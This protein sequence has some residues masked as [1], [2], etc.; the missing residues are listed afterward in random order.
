[1]RR[2]I[3]IAF[4]GIFLAKDV[5][6]LKVHK[7]PSNLE[8]LFGSR[9]LSD[10]EEE[11][12]TVCESEECRKMAN[13]LLRNMNKSVSPCDDFYEYACGR[14]SEQNPIPEGYN[15]W[16]VFHILQINK[17]DQ[18]VQE[19]VEEEPKEDDLRA[20]KIAKKWYKACM[21]TD[22][23]E[24]QGIDPL[25]STLTCL[26]GWPMI[27]DQWDEQEYN[28]QKVDDQ[29]MR[30]TGR[31]AFYDVRV[32]RDS[33]VVQIDSPHLPVG[34]HMLQRVMKFGSEE[35]EDDEEGDEELSKSDEDPSNEDEQS[36]EE[37]EP[38]S[39]GENNSK[40]IKNDDDDDSD[41]DDYKII[42]VD[43]GN[44]SGDRPDD[45]DDDDD[46]DDEDGNSVSGDS[47]DDDDD[48]NEIHKDVKKK[49]DQKKVN[50]GHRRNKK[51]RHVG[52]RKSGTRIIKKHNS[53]KTR[54]QKIKRQAEVG[55]KRQHRFIR[56]EKSH[57]WKGD[58]RRGHVRKVHTK[59]TNKILDNEETTQVNN[60]QK[61]KMTL[62]R[63]MLKKYT[64]YVSKV[65][66]IIA[67]ER[68]TEI[69]QDRLKKDIEDMF[70]FHLR[71]ANIASTE[72][73]FNSL[74]NLE[75]TLRDFQE[76]YDEKESET[77]KSKINWVNKIKALF[78][79][80]YESVNDDLDL[81]IISPSYI[82][83]LISLLDETSNR[84][85]VNYIH[86]NFISRIIKT[87]T[88][89]M[90]NLYDEWKELVTD[91]ST[92]ERSNICKSSKEIQNILAYEF[93]RRYFSD[94]KMRTASNMIKDIKDAVED[95]IKKSD[96]MDENA[97]NFALAKVKHLKEFIGYPNWYKNTTIIQEYFKELVIGSSYY[98]NTIR[99][100]R[101]VKLKGL[102]K[103][104]DNNNEIQLLD[105]YDPSELL[106]PITVNALYMPF[107][108][109]LA[110]TA[111]DFQSPWYADG[112]PR[113]VNF[114]TIGFVIAHE[115]NHGFDNDGYMYDK[116]GD[117][118]GWFSSMA[119]AYDKKEDCFVEQFNNYPIDQKTNEKIKNYGSKTTSDNIADTMGLQAIF[120][121]YQ[122]KKSETPDAAL[123]GMEDFTDNQ[124]FFLSF[125]NLWCEAI[126]PESLINIAKDDE[127]SIARLRVIGSVSNSDDFAT[128]YNCSVG[129]PMNPPKKC[130]IWK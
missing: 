26:G 115:V 110:I 107:L 11:K 125:A 90:T 126:K 34:S 50:I 5:T 16:S 43:D 109:A 1:M 6:L 4:I 97:K 93:V 116:D 12:R 84:T 128:A 28:W 7:Y 91:S 49:I 81:N 47:D 114:G 44:G 82:E 53:H 22:A 71:L 92:S 96:W 18:Q 57:V 27:T 59:R 38:G 9:K 61:T 32:D 74:F 105:E 108:N 79:E 117:F 123:P 54:G 63:L 67:K 60:T 58:R 106:N 24:K 33:K 65:A 113:S 111:A 95:L 73:I 19:I 118:L 83:S 127:H 88:S 52:Q 17:T 101:Y 10:N 14:W 70:E 55:L 62:K 76:W 39:E 99:Y 112:R 130:N 20:V 56:R 42:V 23:I 119:G 40:F 120:K 129:S 46:D 72:P 2:F 21:D 66:H 102:R 13:T 29:Y 122:K 25:V 100:D 37:Q 75:I 98:E 78:E 30:L 48:T 85:I 94:N 8:R 77:V 121:A 15:K 86:W 124:L 51:L 104:S 103:L 80:A 35:A 36:N 45:D 31:N 64:D 41:D 68:E 69:S 3:L 89:E 87:T